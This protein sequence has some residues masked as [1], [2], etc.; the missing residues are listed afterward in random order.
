MDAPGLSAVNQL[1]VESSFPSM[2]GRASFRRARDRS[3]RR[4]FD[5]RQASF[6]MH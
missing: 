5:S 1:G 6:N 4:V 2:E 3:M